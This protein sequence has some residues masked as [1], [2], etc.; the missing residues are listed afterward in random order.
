M[1]SV[2]SWSVYALGVSS[3]A[4]GRGNQW[5]LARIED[6]DRAVVIAV[7]A[8]TAIMRA[9]R[10]RHGRMHNGWHGREVIRAAFHRSTILHDSVILVLVIARRRPRC[11]F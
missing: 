9:G 1:L 11:A 3:C 6:G 2:E 8:R 10:L 7:H 4:A 5:Q